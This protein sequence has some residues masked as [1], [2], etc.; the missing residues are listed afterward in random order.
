MFIATGKGFEGHKN[1][2]KTGFG[3]ISL[4]KLEGFKK[5]SSIWQM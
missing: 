5:E 4:G 3:R 2:L 1:T